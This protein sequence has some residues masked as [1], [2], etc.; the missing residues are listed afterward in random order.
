MASAYKL[1]MTRNENKNLLDNGVN[2]KLQRTIEKNNLSRR[3]LVEHLGEVSLADMIDCH[4]YGIKYKL[5]NR[6]NKIIYEI[7]VDSLKRKRYKVINF[8]SSDLADMEL[9][10]EYRLAINQI[11]L[12]NHLLDQIMQPQVSLIEKVIVKN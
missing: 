1:F 5:V 4:V 9:Q 2:L 8:D 3:I 11:D 12:E 7:L 10:E 6:E